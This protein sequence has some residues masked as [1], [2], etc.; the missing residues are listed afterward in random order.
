MINWFFGDEGTRNAF[1][2][3]IADIFHSLRRLG[4]RASDIQILYNDGRIDTSEPR[5]ADRNLQLTEEQYGPGS[6]K[7]ATKANFD[8]AMLGLEG[9]GKAADQFIC[10]T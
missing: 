6:L 7:S 4:Y 3:T 8:S 9:L 2:I 10:S 1:L 5:N